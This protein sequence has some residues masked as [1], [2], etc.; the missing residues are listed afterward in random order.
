MRRAIVALSARRSAGQHPGLLLQRYLAKP[1]AGDAGDPEEK[2]TLLQSAIRAAQNA[3]LKQLY[4]AAYRRWEASLPAG[5]VRKQ[6]ASAGRLIVGLGSENVLEAGITLHHTYGL[7]VLPG[8]GLKGLAAH[9]CDQVWG[10]AE[11]RFRKGGAYHQLLFGTTDE[12]GCILFYDG[13]LVPGSER[14]PL[15]LDVMTPHHLHWLDGSVPPTDFD[16]PNPVPFLSVSGTFLIALS[17]CGPESDQAMRWTELCAQCLQDALQHWGIGGKTSSGYG[18]LM[19]PPPPP[20]PGPYKGKAGETVR[21]VLLEERTRRG[22]WRAQIVGHSQTGP[23]QNTEQVPPD[24]KPGDVVMLT[25][26]SVNDREAAFR[27]P[28]PPAAGGGK[29]SEGRR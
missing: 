4:E 28:T 26:S 6:L 12:S 9:Y 25:L 13:W 11:E 8:S 21:A 22:G 15:K 24:A 27:W 16:S 3:E 7:P 29:Q 1:A 17:W 19:P 5:A 14:A 23:I 2:R 20:P 10:T 18:R